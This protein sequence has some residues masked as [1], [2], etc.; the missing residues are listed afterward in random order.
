MNKKSGAVMY[1]ARQIANEILR[2]AWEN[3]LEITQLQINKLVYFLHGHHI[4]K[5]GTPLVEDEFQAWQRG[6]VHTCLRQAFKKY[7]DRPIEE[8]AMR[9]N[10]VTRV[11]SEFEP[12]LSN[13]ALSII[14]EYLDFYL[15]YTAGQLVEITHAAETPWSK[16]MEN[17]SNQI[18]IG[19][20]IRNSLI[21]ERF[22]GLN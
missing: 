14:N 2:R 20:K 17:A 4:R 7:G 15:N 11:E 18:N 6:P 16:T 22:E 9:F 19:M 12:V 13:Q 8:L 1:D 10:P 5:F 3:D 21:A